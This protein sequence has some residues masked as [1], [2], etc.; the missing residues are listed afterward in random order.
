[1]VTADF[2]QAKN[3]FSSWSSPTFPAKPFLLATAKIGQ[4]CLSLWWDFLSARQIW[5]LK[6]PCLYCPPF[7]VWVHLASLITLLI[8]CLRDQVTHLLGVLLAWCTPWMV[9]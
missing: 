8:P 5:A 3:L 6:Y 9:I 2:Y 4:P 1:M 7:V